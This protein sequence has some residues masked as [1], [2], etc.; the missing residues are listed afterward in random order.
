MKLSRVLCSCSKVAAVVIAA[1]SFSDFATAATTKD[2]IGPTGLGNSGNWYTAANWSPT[3]VPGSF[4]DTNILLN[5]GTSAAIDYDYN[6][7]AVTIGNLY[8]NASPFPR[9]HPTAALNISANTLTAMREHVGDSGAGGSDGAGAINQSGGINT[10]TGSVYLGYNA[11]DNGAYT[12]SSGTLMVTDVKGPEESVGLNGVGVFNQSGGTNSTT[13]LRI[14]TFAGAN[15]AYTLSGGTLSATG[16]TL[17]ANGVIVGGY[18]GGS[19]PSPQP[20]GTGALTVSG[21]GVLNTDDL[22]VFTTSGSLLN[23]NG[24]TINT[25]KMVIIGD[26]SLFNW[27]SGTLHIT[28]SALF[29][30]GPNTSQSWTAFGSVLNLGTSQTLSLAGNEAIGNVGSFMLTVGSGGTSSVS[31]ALSISG[32]GTLKLNGGALSAAEIFSSGIFTINTGSV[33]TGDVTLKSSSTLGI[34]LG[35]TARGSQYGALTASGQLA[36]D[37]SLVVTL[38]SFTPSA[39][40]MFDVLDWAPGKLSGTFSSLQLPA[41]AGGLVWDTSQLYTTG[42]LSVGLPGDFDFN[43]VVDAADYVVW[44]KGLGTT[45]T[46]N[47]YNVWRTHFGQSAGSSAGASTNATVPEPATLVLLTLT[48]AGRCLRRGRAQRKRDSMIK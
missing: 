13:T 25:P 17:G 32:T 47:D 19:P 26:P 33:A 43:G 9:L 30:P 23:L 46:Q 1:L 27:T 31:G 6:G 8:I 42:V 22:V 48:A 29:E 3:G 10:A 12:L 44:R 20:G 14:G 34:G 24:G 35:G 40:Q 11:T 15:G 2:W 39:G 45:Y 16:G 21:T 28:T 18:F 37:G 4:D 41:L 5:N 7:P 36:L 38:N